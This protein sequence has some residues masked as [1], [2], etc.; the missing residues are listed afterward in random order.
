MRALILDPGWSRGALAA[1]RS[2]GRAGWEVGLGLPGVDGLAMHSRYVT[3]LHPVPPPDVSEAGLVAAVAAACRRIGYD[4]VFAAGDAEVL[5]LSALR[6]R[7]PTAVP[8]PDDE[9]VRRLFDKLELAQLASA[10]GLAT[11]EVF[12]ADEATLAG[13]RS[14]VVVKERLHT[15]RA[16]AGTSRVEARF[17]TGAD[18]A[19]EAAADV[20]AAGGDPVFQLVVPGDLLA[21]TV[22]RDRNGINVG[23]VQQIAGRIW[24][25]PA[26]ISVRAYTT[27]VDET[28]AKGVDRLLDS[29]GWW[30]LAQAQFLVP[31]DGVPQLIDVNA[32]YYG[33]LALACSA[34]VDL[35]LMWAQIAVGEHVSPVAD[36]PADVRYQWLEGDVRRAVGQRSGGLL[37]DLV[38]TFRSSAGATHS[39]RDRRDRAPSRHYVG[40][41]VG[42]AGRK[43]RHRGRR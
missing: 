7:I 41:L 3:H 13:V 21:L 30:G 17:A 20:R 29:I 25:V 37:R 43:L 11:P 4:V 18:E 24:P 1:V 10:A 42:R 8:Y 22:L 34:G 27:D 35:P 6:D 38:G 36:A 5:A 31:D 26:G 32:R 23:R 40:H 39:I 15:R 28:L 9:A 33:S 2:L 19:R 14:P 16:P 12:V